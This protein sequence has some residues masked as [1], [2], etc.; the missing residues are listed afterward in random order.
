MPDQ[1]KEHIFDPW[2]SASPSSTGLGLAITRKIIEEHGGRIWLE[3]TSTEGTSF[4]L[5]LP[6]L[7]F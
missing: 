2:V 7:I 4:G 6:I 5:A 3:S 1:I